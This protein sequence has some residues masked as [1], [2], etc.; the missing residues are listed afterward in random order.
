[1]KATTLILVVLLTFVWSTWLGLLAAGATRPPAPPSSACL[2]YVSDVP[3]QV[4]LLRADPL[5]RIARNF[6]SAAEATEL[7]V[8][9]EPLLAPSTVSDNADHQK[10]HASSHRVSY[11]AY[12]PRGSI[13]E[14]PLID[15]LER[16][17]SLLAGKGVQN[18]ETLQ[19][20]RYQ[21]TGQYYRTHC[22][23]FHDRPRSQRTTTIFVYLNDTRGEGATHFPRLDLHVYPEL[24]KACIWENCRLVD[25]EMEC[26]PRLEHAG[27]PLLSED[28]VKYGLNIWFR[29]GVFR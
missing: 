21:G 20:L 24:G 15:A 16:R 8:R 2:V 18:M 12:L 9:Y 3:M 29:S 11:S 23:Y 17:A 22:D 4:E 7:I 10:T 5:I 28:N 27:L 19:L 1:M 6:L 25:R 13:E 14:H 26:D